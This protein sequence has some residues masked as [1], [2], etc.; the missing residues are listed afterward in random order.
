VS[1]SFSKIFTHIKF[2][3]NPSNRSHVFHAHKWA[4]ARGFSQK[5][6]KNASKET[7]VK[8]ENQY[9][10]AGKN[11]LEKLRQRKEKNGKTK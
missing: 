10:P 2:H 7:E 1:T 11:V 8:T 5:L 3:E 4:E 9:R 6:L